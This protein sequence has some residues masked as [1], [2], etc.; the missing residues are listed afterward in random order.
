[1]AKGRAFAEMAYDCAR[2][3]SLTL[4]TKCFLVQHFI[5][6]AHP[7]GALAAVLMAMAVI[8]SPQNCKLSA[9]PVAVTRYSNVST[10]AAALFS[11]F[12]RYDQIWIFKVSCDKSF[13]ALFWRP[14]W[15]TMRNPAARMFMKRKSSRGPAEQTVRPG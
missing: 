5:P 1:M 6:S 13:L 3:E 9:K 11:M 2:C 7:A 12:Q 8:L 10:S 14:G 15:V 4:T